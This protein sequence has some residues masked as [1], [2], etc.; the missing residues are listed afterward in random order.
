MGDKAV[1]LSFPRESESFPPRYCWGGGSPFPC[2]PAGSQSEGQPGAVLG[3]AREPALYRGSAGP[4]GAA[5][6]S[7]PASLPSCWWVQPLQLSRLV[8]PPAPLGWCRGPPRS[9]SPAVLRALVHVLRSDATGQTAGCLSGSPRDP[10]WDG[11][12]SGCRGPVV[13]PPLSSRGVSDRVSAAVQVCAPPPPQ[14]P[15]SLVDAP[16]S[17]WRRSGGPRCVH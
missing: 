8:A 4:D 11:P 9:G 7:T 16:R 10:P 1:S 5:G 17:R 15:G 2:P 12:G 14:A 6:T 13:S 3:P